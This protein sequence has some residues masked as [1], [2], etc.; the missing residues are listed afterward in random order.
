M[1]YCPYGTQIEK[2]ILPVINALGNKIKFSLK[3]VDYA[4]HG[5]KEI[6][7]NSRQY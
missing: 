7:E 6:D 3:F 2:G 1:S 4:M 5:K